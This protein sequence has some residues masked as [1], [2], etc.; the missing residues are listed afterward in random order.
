MAWQRS[1]NRL[2]V[3]LTNCPYCEGMS[4]IFDLEYLHTLILY[5]AAERED[6]AMVG[7]TVSEVHL[8]SCAQTPSLTVLS[9]AQHP[10]GLPASSSIIQTAVLQ[11]SVNIITFAF[12]GHDTACIGRWC[13]AL[14]S[15]AGLSHAFQLQ[16]SSAYPI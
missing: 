10:H 2:Y 16:Q 1:R 3:S 7:S 8:K 4:R 5:H 14:S 9:P 13:W 15:G 11:R 6:H 12:I